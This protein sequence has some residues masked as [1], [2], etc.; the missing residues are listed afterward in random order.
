MNFR[1]LLFSFFIFLSSCQLLDSSLGKDF[2]EK[3]LKK[4]EV[5]SYN[6]ENLFDIEHDIL[7]NRH[8]QDYMYLPKSSE[9]KRSGCQSIRS[10]YWQ[11]KCFETDWTKEKLDLK[12]AQLSK[13]IR[14]GNENKIP[15][16]LSVTEIENEKV[17]KRL[18]KS[19]NFEHFIITSGRDERGIE[20]AIFYNNG[21]EHSLKLVKHE[22]HELPGRTTRSILE[23]EFSINNER[24]F[25]IYTNHW[26]SQGSPTAARVE[27]AKFLAELIQKKSSKVEGH[28]IALGDFNT[29]PQEK[30][31]PFR[32][33]L[34]EKTP[35]RDLDDKFQKSQ[36]VE[37]NQKTRRVLGTY[38]YSPKMSWNLLDRVFVDKS[39]SDDKGL[40]ALPEDY[41]IYAPDF[42]VETHIN[43][44]KSSSHFGSVMQGVPMRA[45]FNAEKSKNAGFSDHFPVIFKLAYPSRN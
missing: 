24:S 32:D 20:V 23:A 5:M 10:N 28:I 39:L 21:G 43:K 2:R 29:L 11:K 6:L 27:Q 35:L 12:I 8:L 33:V 19:L 4:I 1:I 9:F 44:D 15:D 34:L 30:P 38:F 42:A 3:E 14:R 41:L 13:M 31:H 37:K 16:I 7:K 18:A 22:E 45:N 40:E 26:P 25:V 17:A 36:F